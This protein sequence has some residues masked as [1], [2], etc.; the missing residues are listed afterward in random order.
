MKWYTSK[1][2]YVEDVYVIVCRPIIK[3]EFES[4]D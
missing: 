2:L 1:A 4:M 3:L